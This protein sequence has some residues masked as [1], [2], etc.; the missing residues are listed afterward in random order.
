[1]TTDNPRLRG[2]LPAPHIDPQ[3]WRCYNCSKLI[4]FRRLSWKRQA[5]A[6]VVRFGIK[7]QENQLAHVIATAIS[8]GGIQ[9]QRL[10]VQ[11]GSRM[12]M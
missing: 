1:M 9:A 5:V 6:Y 3:H 10:L 12:K 2:A 4:T 8:V 7:P 11:L